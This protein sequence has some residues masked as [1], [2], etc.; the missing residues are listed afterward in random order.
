MHKTNEKIFWNIRFCFAWTYISAYN[1]QSKR[2]A[3]AATA[4]TATA[5]EYDVSRLTTWQ[6]HKLIY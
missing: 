6:T 3:A 1:E 4:A 2:N 5:F